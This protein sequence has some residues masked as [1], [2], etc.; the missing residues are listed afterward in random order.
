VA[1]ASVLVG[2]GLETVELGVHF[3]VRLPG[4]IKF[5]L[6]QINLLVSLH[7]LIFNLVVVILSVFEKK[8]QAHLLRPRLFKLFDRVISLLLDLRKVTIIAGELAVHQSLVVLFLE[9]GHIEV[10]LGDLAL[11][12]V[13]V[14]LEILDLAKPVVALVSGFLTIDLELVLELLKS[15]QLERRLS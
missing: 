3:V 2:S 14:C 15:V 10:E 12:L 1:S 7:G 6:D 13:V 4:V 9:L 11:Q 5:V 8:S